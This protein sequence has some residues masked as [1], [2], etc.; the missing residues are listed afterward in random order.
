VLG[1]RA[2]YSFRARNPVALAQSV[3][4]FELI[5][6]KVYNRPHDVIISRYQMMLKL[7][8]MTIQLDPWQPKP[9]TVV[10]NAVQ[11]AAVGFEPG[12][13]CGAGFGIGLPSGTGAGLLGGA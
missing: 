12:F 5:G 2:P 3:Q 6:R 1:D 9:D 8:S 7:V 10:A 13:G 4:R 11:P